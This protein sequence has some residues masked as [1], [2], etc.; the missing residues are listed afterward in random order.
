M[1]TLNPNEYI[2]ISSAYPVNGAYSLSDIDSISNSPKN[3]VTS[4]INNVS[5]D[6]KVVV[7]ASTTKRR[8][9]SLSL[10]ATES[11]QN[12]IVER[13]DGTT[14]VTMFYGDLSQYDELDITGLSVDTPVIY[15]LMLSN[16][17]N[18]VTASRNLEALNSALSKYRNVY[19]AG[20]GICQINGRVIVPSNT[21]VVFQDGLTLKQRNGINSNNLFVNRAFEDRALGTVVTPTWTAGYEINL[22]WVGHGLTADQDYVWLRPS[23]M[24][25]AVTTGSSQYLG[26]F[27]VISVTDAD[28]VILMA[29]RNPTAAPSL[30][31]A[32]WW[33]SKADVNITIDGLKIDYNVDNNS[34]PSTDIGK[35]CVVLGGIANSEIKNV[36]VNNVLKFCINLGAAYCTN[37]TN[38]KSE[39]T[40]SDLVKIYG[41]AYNCVADGIYGIS[42][43]DF[44]TMQTK[45]SSLF[46]QY[47]WT[48]GD[49]LNCQI[50]NA[51]GSCTTA[52]HVSSLYC[53]PDEIADDI[54]F[55]NIIGKSPLFY[56]I[57]VK[58]WTTGEK[59]VLKK[60]T[61]RNCRSLMSTTA[62]VRV[63]DL[64]TGDLTLENCV[65]ESETSRMADVL[66]TGILKRLHMHNCSYD[67]PAVS[68][69][70]KYVINV[71]GT[72]DHVSVG[73]GRFI[74]QGTQQLRL[75][76]LGATAVVRKV[77]VWGAT[78]FMD[79]V[80]FLTAGVTGT[81]Q[82]SIDSCDINRGFSVFNLSANANC[83]VSNCKIETA[84]NGVLRTT[85]AVTC[86]L[87][88][89]GNTLVSG[90]WVVVV[91][92]TP[93]ISLFGFEIN[94]DIGATGIARTANAHCKHITTARGTI[95]TNELV[96][97]DVTG[98][99]NSWHQVTSPVTNVF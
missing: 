35:H 74:Q 87:K 90:N 43:D 50:R 10:V 26:V 58:G 38:V 60:M 96:V 66:G 98:A 14:T 86:S 68:G 17:D 75:V 27:R 25:L 9:N 18:L 11:P 1:I 88:A 54:V 57:R 84:T 61:I 64:T 95:T 5:G 65:M 22:N 8:V 19:V 91:S 49:L 83:S 3:I 69:T 52:A 53:S 81:P 94:A 73:A 24:A 92:G 29:N 42:G 76:N 34:T 51:V 46:A 41:P 77:S 28:N 47:I 4:I 15:E 82:C 89:L 37:V 56:G 72:V 85:G 79:N 20:N 33:A 45:E 31:G 16:D 63:D 44:I 6:N 80:V 70:T 78:L 13:T 7:P 2:R 32:V 21:K 30:T 40:R 36:I 55:E 59:G 93:V 62:M 99:A 97:C 71:D 48:Y 23:D 39:E 67:V 12:V